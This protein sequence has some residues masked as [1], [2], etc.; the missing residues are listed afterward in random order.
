VS[1]ILEY[2]PLSLYTEKTCRSIIRAP[3]FSGGAVTFEHFGE[4][5]LLKTP[6]DAA[7]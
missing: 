6:F 3:R 5:G 1:G 4:T 2:Y 7:F